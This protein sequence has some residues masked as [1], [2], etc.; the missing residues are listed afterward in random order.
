MSNNDSV[1]NYEKL[2]KWCGEA[3]EALDVQNSVFKSLVVLKGELRVGNGVADGTKLDQ[4]VAVDGDILSTAFNIPEGVVWRA[5]S[6]S[7]G[8]YKKVNDV[9]FVGFLATNL[10]YNFYFELQTTSIFGPARL[11]IPQI[12]TIS[13]GFTFWIFGNPDGILDDPVV[14]QFPGDDAKQYE[15]NG[16]FISTLTYTSKRLDKLTWNQAKDV[17]VVD[18]FDPTIV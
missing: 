17:W 14:G 1:P 12:D 5:P 6:G 13:D 10:H 2:V 16:T 7:S 8:G 9:G 11:T 18:T 4:T 3:I 15:V